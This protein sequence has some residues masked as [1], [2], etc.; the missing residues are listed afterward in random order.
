ME[1]VYLPDDSGRFYY[2]PR[3]RKGVSISD[4]FGIPFIQSKEKDY[5]PF[6]ENPGAIVFGVTEDTLKRF[7]DTAEMRDKEGVEKVIMN[8]FPEGVRD[9]EV[10]FDKW[11]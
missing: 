11:W 5:N 6:E 10:G 9:K 7:F 4:E 1:L 2:N 3:F 8:E